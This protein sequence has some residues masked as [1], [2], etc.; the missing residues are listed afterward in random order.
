MQ[1][2]MTIVE[3][4]NRTTKPLNFMFDGVPGVV[5]PGYKIG[6][7][8]EVLPAGR[9]GQPAT[10][11]LTKTTAEYA[12]R[13]NVK[14]GTEDAM[15]GE[16]EFLVGVADR[17]PETGALVANPHWL[18]NEITY[19]EQSDSVERFDRSLLEP[20]AQNATVVQSAGF[21]RGRAGAAV[22]PF[23]YADGPVDPGRQ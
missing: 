22:A 5:R 14:M 7:N 13:Q 10:T 1:Q 16:A 15:S 12:R 8:G 2:D 20:R 18:Y 19:T 17:D 9:D 3:A 21:P 11:P 23:Q 6:A 4:V